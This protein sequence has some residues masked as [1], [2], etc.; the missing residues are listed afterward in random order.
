MI[1]N[2]GERIL[3]LK[4][5]KMNFVANEKNSIK[6]VLDSIRK[7]GSQF[8]PS[9][10]QLNVELQR[11]FFWQTHYD[12]FLLKYVCKFLVCKFSWKDEKLDIY[13]KFAVAV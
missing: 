2:V 4:A 10:F 12:F 5:I 7:M 11:I 3:N 1:K 9:T 13:E 6:L 8:F